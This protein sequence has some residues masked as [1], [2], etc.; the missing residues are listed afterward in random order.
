MSLLL[1]AAVSQLGATDCGHVLRDAGFDL[2]CG[3]QLCNWKVMRGEVRAVPTWHRDDLGVELV[4]DDAAIAQLSPVNSGDGT[5]IR[6]SMVSDVDETAAVFLDI[7]VHRDGTVE[8]TERIPTSHWKPVSFLIAIDPPFDWIRFELAKRGSGRAVLAQ[9]EAVVSDECNGVTAIETVRPDG[10]SCLDGTDCESGLCVVA[11]MIAAGGSVVG[12]VCATCDPDLGGSACSTPG[13]VCGVVDATSPLHTAHL[14]C[15][16]VGS[17]EL[18]EKCITKDECGS[19]P[20]VRWVGAAS[21]TCSSCWTSAFCRDGL[22]CELAWIGEVIGQSGA[23]V[24]GAGEQ[25]ALPGE[26]CAQHIDCVS[27]HCDGAIRNECRDGRPC[28]SS[29]DCPYEDDLTQ[30][31]CN[32]IGIQGGRCE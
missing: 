22:V 28:D 24:C 32:P 2:W 23:M 6:F 21:G 16:P 8:R 27:N 7:D 30:G 14:A 26:P 4:G 20:C 31:A 1:I 5:C 11:P 9:I 17:R 29:A 25:L 19:G 13:E 10:A 18:G 3:G 12:K 15:I